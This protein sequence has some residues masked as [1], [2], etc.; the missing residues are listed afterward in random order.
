[1]ESWSKSPISTHFQIVV[2]TAYRMSTTIAII[3]AYLFGIASVHMWRAIR[4]L[5]ER[6]IGPDGPSACRRNALA[7]GWNG[8]GPLP[9]YQFPVAPTHPVKGCI[10]A[11]S[12]MTNPAMPP[13]PP[14]GWKEFKQRHHL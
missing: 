2:I 1:V 13:E 4:W 5:S 12:D 3:I 8:I 7:K 10:T 6:G 11:T 9:T 14:V